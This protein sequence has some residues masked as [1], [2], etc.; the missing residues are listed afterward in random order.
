MNGSTVDMFQAMYTNVK[1]ERE[2]RGT[3]I[4]FYNQIYIQK[5]KVYLNF[6]EPGIHHQ[7]GSPKPKIPALGPQSPLKQSLP[8]P[9]MTYQTIYSSRGSGTPGRYGNTPGFRNYPGLALTPRTKTL[10]VF[11]ESSTNQLDR[12]N[13]EIKKNFVGVNKVGQTLNFGNPSKYK[14]SQSLKSHL[15]KSMKQK[16]KI[17]GI[18]TVSGR[19]PV[20][21]PPMVM[22][23]KWSINLWKI[24]IP[25]FSLFLLIF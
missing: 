4:D 18:T 15:I 25:K 10:Y 6:N 11:G 22:K 13:T 7:A 5:M 8:P 2:E 23:S 14:N 9:R 17:S 1:L 12:A 20:G 21:P 24:V 16:N 3:I 19:P